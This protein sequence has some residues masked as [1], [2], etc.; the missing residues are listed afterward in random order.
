[1]GTTSALS[2]ISMRPLGEPPMEMSK[3]TTGFSVAM[4]VDRWM[5]V[6]SVFEFCDGEE[7]QKDPEENP[8]IANPYSY[9][10]EM[11]FPVHRT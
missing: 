3:K 6:Y 5:D 4:V 1:M 11:T 2:S 8:P 10:T 7:Q 9:Q